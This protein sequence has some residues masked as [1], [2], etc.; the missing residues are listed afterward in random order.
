MLV[1]ITPK[2]YSFQKKNL[3]T[4]QQKVIHITAFVV[5]V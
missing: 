4:I 5:Q 1:G 3:D 2:V